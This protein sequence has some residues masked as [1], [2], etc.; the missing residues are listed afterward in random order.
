MTARLA[1]WLTL[2]GGYTALAYATR[3][4]EGDPPDDLLYRYST[5]VSGAVQYAITLMVVLWITRGPR[6][7]E[8]LGLRQ[9]VSWARASGLALLVVVGIY[10]LIAIT[11]PLLHAGEEQGLT[12]PGW[13]GSR[14]GAY[15]A[16]AVVIAVVA[17]IVEELMFRGAG[18]SLLLPFGAAIA[19]GGTGIAFGL[20]HGLVFGLV[21]LTAFGVGLA[22][23]RRR[24]ASIYPCMIVHAL[25][26]SVSLVLAVTT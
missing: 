17:P 8:L 3:A 19:V 25:F 2:V 4:S 14:A 11:E 23:L 26:N 16:N 9:P 21:A 7:G 1:A 6:R 18:Y 12:P 22:W 15:L 20:V 10:V 13:D 24:T 5:A